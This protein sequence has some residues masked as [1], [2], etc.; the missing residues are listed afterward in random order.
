MWC[1]RVSASPTGSVAPPH[2]VSAEA[3]ALQHL[4]DQVGAAVGQRPR[5]E[6]LDERV[7]AEP[8][9][10]A[11]FLEEAL[12]RLGVVGVLGQQDLDRRLA[13]QDRVLALVDGA[14]AAT[15]EQGRDTVVPE[16]VP[17]RD[18][19]FSSSGHARVPKLGGRRSEE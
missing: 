18:F 5:V 9:G 8:R 14:H 15:T 16:R 6:H 10:G 17:D 7:V 3:L 19:A 1:A 11:R 4:H 2:Q 12:D 13:A